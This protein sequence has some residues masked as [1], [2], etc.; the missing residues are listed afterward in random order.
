MPRTTTKPK[1]RKPAATSQ[2]EEVLTLADAAAYLRVSEEDVL[3]LTR[4]QGLPG[5]QIGQEW[6]FLKA[7]IEDWLRAPETRPPGLDFWQTQLGAF[8]DDPH[9][10]E[11]LREIYD[12]RGRPMTEEG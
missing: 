6:R 9:L 10:E 11:M 12:K 5:R 4:E 3:R 2:P 1:P 7:A 8:K